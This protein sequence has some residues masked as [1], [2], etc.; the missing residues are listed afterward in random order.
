MNKTVGAWLVSAGP[1][2]NCG[3]K[4]ALVE[5][6]EECCAC[7]MRVETEVDCAGKVDGEQTRDTQ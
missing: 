5:I 3:Y 1:E 6:D 7:E 2:E 4:V